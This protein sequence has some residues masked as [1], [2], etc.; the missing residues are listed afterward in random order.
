VA[1]AGRKNNRDLVDK[2][3]NLTIKNA[4][5]NTL[6][7]FESTACGL[8]FCFPIGQIEKSLNWATLRGSRLKQRQLQGG[9]IGR[10]FV[11]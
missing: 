4:I 6:K 9:S 11:V 3:L 1:M 5:L 2:M 10:L 7:T 8:R